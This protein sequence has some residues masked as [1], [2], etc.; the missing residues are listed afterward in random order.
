MLASLYC[1]TEAL[2]FIRLV[3]TVLVLVADQR[4]LNTGSSVTAELPGHLH[5]LLEEQRPQLRARVLAGVIREI[6]GMETEWIVT[7]QVHMSHCAVISQLL[8][9]PPKSC[10]LPDYPCVDISYRKVCNN[11]RYFSKILPI[12]VPCCVRT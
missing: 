7:G 12:N 5:C 3:V 9:L 2:L 4:G 11:Y 10:R 6:P 8:N 1:L